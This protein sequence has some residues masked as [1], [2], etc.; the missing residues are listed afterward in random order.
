MKFLFRLVVKTT[1]WAAMVFV[2]SVLFQYGTA[3]FAAG[4]QKEWRIWQSWPSLLSLPGKAPATPSPATP[5]A[6]PSPLSL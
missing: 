4:A 1:F 5:A 2:F 3:D 6:P